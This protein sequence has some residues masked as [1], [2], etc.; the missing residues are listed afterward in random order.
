ML[1]EIGNVRERNAWEGGGAGQRGMG[2]D[3][4]IL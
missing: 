2:N 4:T 3:M 1:T